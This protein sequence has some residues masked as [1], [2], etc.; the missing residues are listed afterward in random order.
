VQTGNQVETENTRK[1]RV[2]TLLDII[3]VVTI[4]AILTAYILPRV[5]GYVFDDRIIQVKRDIRVFEASLELYKLDNSR[6][7]TTDQG[8]AALIKKPSDGSAPNWRDGGYM[9]KIVK[10]PW[11]NDYRYSY[12]GS[13]GEF[14]VFSLGADGATGGHGEAADIGNW[15]LDS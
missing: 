15:N 12:P 1:K 2:F 11:G 9:L 4:I 3:I 10:D 13:I 7:P 8:L 6:Y 5:I 14:D